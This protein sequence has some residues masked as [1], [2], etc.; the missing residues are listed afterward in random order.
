[1]IKIE[2]IKKAEV[3][4]EYG[5]FPLTKKYMNYSCIGDF[6]VPIFFDIDI[7]SVEQVKKNIN[8]IIKNNDLLRATLSAKNKVIYIHKMPSLIE[9]K[10]IEVKNEMEIKE[11]IKY[12]CEELRNRGIEETILY[13]ICLFRLRHK[14]HF[15]GIFNHLISDG[16]YD[17]KYF[18]HNINKITVLENELELFDNYIKKI[19][20][21]CND[22]YYKYKILKGEF[23]KKYV[24]D[25][26]IREQIIINMERDILRKV[27]LEDYILE[28]VITNL[29]NSF[30]NEEQIPINIISGRK[31]I[32][33]GNIIKQVG[34]FHDEIAIILDSRN[35]KFLEIYHEE[36]SYPYRNL[37][38][39]TSYD[40][41][42]EIDCD[43]EPIIISIV[44]DTNNQKNYMKYKGYMPRTKKKYIL[45]IKVLVSLK[46]NYFTLCLAY[47]ENLKEQINSFKKNIG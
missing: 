33:L 9:I 22:I 19:P 2:E 5:I 15:F 46:L 27:S 40:C 42:P 25:V 13:N 28:R 38:E 20:R 32:I 3:E 23:T 30:K 37:T 44:W 6:F 12:L 47:S 26:V 1:M 39:Y 36:L 24:S 43:V 21:R 11:W 18:I 45:S 8:V 35:S 17:F 41:I 14:L 7:E 10:L 4:K 31:K 34:D 16:G 29:Q